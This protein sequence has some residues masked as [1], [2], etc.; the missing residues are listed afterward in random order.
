[1]DFVAKVAVLAA[2]AVVAEV[3]EVSDAAE[4]ADSEKQSNLLHFMLTMTELVLYY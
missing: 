3:A 1:L 2:V 4:V